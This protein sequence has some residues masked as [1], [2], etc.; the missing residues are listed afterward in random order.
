M[1]R[2]GI[3]TGLEFEAA[4]VRSRARAGGFA[5]RVAVGTGLGRARARR[6]GEA[7]IAG[8]VDALLSFGIAGG[9]SPAHG[10]ATVV[11]ATAV[12]AEHLP[13][14][15]CDLAWATRLEDAL[16]PAFPTAQGGIA[17]APDIIAH[18]DD[19]ARLYTVT[20]ALAADM[21]SYGVAE[22]AQAAGLPFTALRVIADTWDESLPDIA[23]HAMT[24]D[25]ALKLGETLGRVLRRPGQIPALIHLG[26][27]TGRARRALR[28]IAKIGAPNVFF[29]AG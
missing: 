23:L 7:L 12:V 26:R 2:V 16:H 6:A 24:P 22:A 18:R 29:A 21:E 20:G 1:I 13:P 28:E 3:V 17:H 9:L 8:G 14:L 25:G 10:S 15:A 5:D 11:V 27:S 4:A 19:K